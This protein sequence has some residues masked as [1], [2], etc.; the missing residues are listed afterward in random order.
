MLLKLLGEAL[1][2]AH[3]LPAADGLTAGSIARRAQLDAEADRAELAGVAATS[4][5]IR[6]ADR[7]P[8]QPALEATVERAKDLLARF[9][10]LSGRRG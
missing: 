6:Y 10:R 1:T 5:E 3:R 2:R 8:P 4:D 7:V 9:A